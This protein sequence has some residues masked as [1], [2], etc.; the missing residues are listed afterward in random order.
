LK[1]GD[2]VVGSLDTQPG[3]FETSFQK[4]CNLNEIE[5]ADPEPSKT[6]N[7]LLGIQK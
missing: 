1:A 2:V 6:G 3:I 7:L 5:H 4:F